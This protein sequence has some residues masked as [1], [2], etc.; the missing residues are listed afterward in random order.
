[1]KFLPPSFQET[2]RV[3]FGKKG[4]SWH[5]VTVAVTR[6]ECNDIEVI[7]SRESFALI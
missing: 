5:R 1:M 3:W 6:S 4:K 2:Q 7:S